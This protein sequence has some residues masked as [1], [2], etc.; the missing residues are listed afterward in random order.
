MWRR[1]CQIITHF[2]VIYE[3]RSVN[4]QIRVCS[5][6]WVPLCSQS[7]LL[8]RR[9]LRSPSLTASPPRSWTALTSE[10][11]ATIYPFHRRSSGTTGP[12]SGLLSAFPRRG[13]VGNC[14]FAARQGVTGSGTGEQG[15]TGQ[16]R[17]ELLSLNWKNHN[18]TKPR[19]WPSTNF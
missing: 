10:Q 1:T 6:P 7:S 9:R 17:A 16:V 18:P 5:V 2:M 11:L 13:R 4:W 14:T 3:A 8:L 12:V 19:A 15:R